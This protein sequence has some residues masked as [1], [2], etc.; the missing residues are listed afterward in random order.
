MKAF[1]LRAFLVLVAIAAALLAR[2]SAPAGF[3]AIEERLADFGW[4]LF[5]EKT[6]EERL[7]LIDI[8]EKSLAEL[9]PWP[10]PRA[11]LAELAQRVRAGGAV[12]QAWDIVLDAPRENDAELAD[13]LLRANAVLAVAF[14]FPGQG[15][16]IASG[17]LASGASVLPCAKPWPRAHGYRAPAES[18]TSLAQGHINPR[19]DADGLVR[20]VPAYVCHG[21]QAY[22]A[23][24][25]AAY[26]ALAA[27]R[28][29]RWVQGELQGDALPAAIPLGAEG[30]LYIP[31]ARDPQAFLAV[32]AADVLAGRLPADLLAGRYAL[33]GSTALGLADAV[34]TP[35]AGAQSGLL[36]HAELL[37]GLLDARI[38]RQAPQAAVVF[39][40]ALILGALLAFAFFRPIVW[41]LPLAGLLGALLLAAVA[42]LAQGLLAWRPT[43]AVAVLAVFLAGLL[44][45]IGEA[46][47]L[48]RERGRLAELL[49]SFLP[50]PFAARLLRADAALPAAELVEASVLYAD[51]RN[52]TAWS[53]AHAPNEIAALLA[54][55]YAAAV[56]VVAAHGGDVEALEGDAVLAVW[57]GLTPCPDHAA[58][59]LAAARALVARCR[60]E[61]PQASPEELPP[62][63][64]VAIG[65]DAGEVL[66]GTVGSAQRR[67]HIV[68]GLPV[69]RAVRL[70]AQ[71][72][73]LAAAILVGP[74][75]AA[76]LAAAERA[77][78]V[79]RGQFLLEGLT[80]PCEV[81]VDPAADAMA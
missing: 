8:D 55:F 31:Y 53:E 45:G 65:L 51:L 78:L 47:R 11:R 69:T 33:I 23:F 48:L 75:L 15:E 58:R 52:F 7:V 10:W 16:A 54:R 50:A 72:A 70:A 60:A 12:G 63:L 26:L 38:P 25:L 39:A 27:E 81:H 1:L 2:L 14:A 49:T 5:A 20:A 74:G 61:L 17:H 67:R 77:R 35:F 44:L 66:V 19:V 30:E 42:W 32:S 34:A 64:S 40:T 13:E 37:A 28:S 71:S 29:P 6:P 62:P 41:A 43:V 68:L 56:D 36:V 76:R 73:E 57:N 79:A 24:A 59:A 22:P 18:F 46:L 4:R 9:G 3:V 80:A 21:E